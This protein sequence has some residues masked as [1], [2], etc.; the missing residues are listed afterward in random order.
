MAIWEKDASAAESA[1]AAGGV[2]CVTDVRDSDQV[3][4]ALAAAIETIGVPTILVNNA[5]GV[6]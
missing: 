4:A 2:A 3:D 1:E 5:G 6:F